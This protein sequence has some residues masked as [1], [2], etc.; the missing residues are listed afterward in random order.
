MKIYQI[1]L[2]LLAGTMMLSGCYDEKMS[3]Q[4]PDGQGAVVSS[5]IPLALAEQ[6]ANY[7]NIKNYAAEYMPTTQIGLGASADK[8][9]SDENYASLANANFQIFTMGNAMKPIPHGH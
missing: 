7:D 9:L 6:I 8:Y 5:E 3:W 2:P 4:R 1:A